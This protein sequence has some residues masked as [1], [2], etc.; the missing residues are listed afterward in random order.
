[1]TLLTY[2]AALA[3]LVLVPWLAA[4]RFAVSVDAPDPRTTFEAARA[5]HARRA[6]L[7]RED[8]SIL[9]V[10]ARTGPPVRRIACVV[11]LSQIVGSVDKGPHPFDR[12]FYP[13]ADSAWGRFASVLRARNDGVELPPVW[14]QEGEDG[15]YVLDGHHRVAVAR[16]I[17]DTDIRAEVAVRR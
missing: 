10:L 16:A 1:M 9:P 5:R 7:R 17:G 14:L 3:A 4:R 11:P 12:R 15:Y 13:S 2:V 6:L 8:A